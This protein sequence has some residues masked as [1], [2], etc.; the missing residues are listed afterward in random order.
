MIELQTQT[1]WSR[2][3]NE[4]QISLCDETGSIHSLFLNMFLNICPPAG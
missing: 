2:T 4:L 1:D 3:G